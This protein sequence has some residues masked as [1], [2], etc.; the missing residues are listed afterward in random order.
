MSLQNASVIAKGELA[1]LGDILRDEA[2]AAYGAKWTTG[3]KRVGQ[4]ELRLDKSLALEEYK[5]VSGNGVT[6]TG[7]SYQAVAMGT[8]TL[9]QAIQST[10]TGIEISPLTI[11][12]KPA[13]GYRGLLIDVARRFHSIS[14]LK[15]C[16]ELCRLYKIRY[17]Q[18][19]L[20]DDQSFTFPSQAFPKLNTVNT[21]GGP[22]YTK[23]ELKELV[24]YADDRAVTIIPEIDL[25]GHGGAIIRAMP[26][27]FKISGTKPYEHHGTINFANDKV[28]SAVDKLVGEV[29]E[30]FRSSPYF[31]MGGD[32]ADISNADQH[33]DFQAAFKQEGLTGKAQHE[34]FRRFIGQVNQFTRKRGKQLIVWE[35]FGRDAST[36]F[37]I[38]KDVLVMEFESAYYLPNDLLEDG[39]KLINAAWTP[40]YVVNKH[41]WP[42]QKIY[43]WNLAQ[44]GRFSNL[45]PTTTWFN[46]SNTNNILGAQVC[47]WE[48]PEFLEIT[49]SRRI[50]PAMAERVWNPESKRD[51]S[52][53]ASRLAATDQ[54]LSRLIEPVTIQPT[55]LS[56]NGP[57]EFDIPCFT[58]PIR[59][60]LRSRGTTEVRYTLD[61]SVPSASSSL[62]KEPLTVSQTTTVR[63]AQFKNGVQ[64]GFESSMTFYYV[65]PKKPNLAT[66]KPVTSSSGTQG[67]Q[68]PTLAVDDNLDLASSW[69]AG[70]APQWMQV[71]LG[72]EFSVD[73][74]E[75]FPYWDGRRYYQYTIEVSLDGKA[76]T[77]V[78]DKSTNMV[79]ASSQGDVHRL[80]SQKMRYVR[81]NMLKG[82]ANDS[83]HI[84]ELKV[85]EAKP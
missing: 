13:V 68:L 54:L 43:D 73:L 14:T 83:V 51:Y 31:H 70:P 29:C 7:G 3:S 66:G 22:S 27:L 11:Q 42:A 25:P 41:V 64:Q 82:S 15:Q 19:H 53:F 4:I 78:I 59:V 1:K 79:P 26:E 85:W 57:D 23:E 55:G 40:L 69:W 47:T 81:V 5:L 16:V 9:L 71:D 28:I 62:Y 32:E 6:I 24:A 72:K 35:G 63:A 8:A 34:I 17:L 20:T 50:V 21:H 84:V 48:Q 74:I 30:V 76:W 52:D 38:S 61:G 18:L 44:F 39:Y 80:A 36:K 75:L 56:K 2:Q 60:D 10:K 67:Q 58:D 46:A 37:P 33:A 77:K 65:P 12:D 45:Y 49:N